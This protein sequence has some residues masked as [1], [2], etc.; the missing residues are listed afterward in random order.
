V[1]TPADLADCF[2]SLGLQE[3]R[4]D[5]HELTIEYPVLELILPEA[6]TSPCLRPP[7][8][9]EFREQPDASKYHFPLTDTDFT[10]RIPVASA[11]PQPSNLASISAAIQSL[12]STP[13]QSILQIASYSSLSDGEFHIFRF[14][15]E[16]PTN[17]QYQT[18]TEN[19]FSSLEWE[20]E[21]AALKSEKW[22]RLAQDLI[23]RS[24]DRAYFYVY[25]ELKLYSWY[26]KPR[27][28]ERWGWAR[29]GGGAGGTGLLTCGHAQAVSLRAF[30]STASFVDDDDQE[31]IN[32]LACE[33][34]AEGVFPS[35]EDV[36]RQCLFREARLRVE[37]CAREGF[38]RR[39]E[40]MPQ[41]P[42]S[43]SSAQGISVRSKFLYDALR[44][45]LPS[46]RVPD[47][48]CPRALQWVSSKEVT[49]AMLEL[50]G[51]MDLSDGN[52]VSSASAQDLEN[53]LLQLFEECLGETQARRGVRTVKSV[54]SLPEEWVVLLRLW[55]ARTVRLVLIPGYDGRD[56]AAVFGENGEGLIGSGVGEV[57]DELETMLRDA[58][59]E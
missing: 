36:R 22:T 38:W 50:L 57:M 31:V 19:D 9:I 2:Q 17:G 29:D 7:Q 56:I 15:T 42:P 27:R 53:S 14:I 23:N 10:L 11:T 52:T 51:R 41:S 44:H 39:L 54:K 21:R 28:A 1:S 12:S 13:G 35:E 43:S 33:T 59:L 5:Y 24:S 26:L 30:D 48:A 8:N 46:I 45:S 34:C 47:T 3:D 49:V 16:D 55:V 58:R 20:A 4:L 40:D 18:V 37:F 32:D 25:D 6:G